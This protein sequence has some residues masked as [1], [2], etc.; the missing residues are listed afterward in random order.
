ML[1][2]LSRRHSTWREKVGLLGADARGFDAPQKRRFETAKYSKN[3]K[4]VGTEA[5]KGNEVGA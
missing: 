5:N 4:E 2:T 1:L 3:A